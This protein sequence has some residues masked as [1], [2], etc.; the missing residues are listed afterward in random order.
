[1]VKIKH[2]AAYLQY[3]LKILRPDNKTTLTLK[4]LN[5]NLLILDED[6]VE[7]YGHIKKNKPVLRPLSDLFNKI[8]INNVYFVPIIELGEIEFEEYREVKIFD[9]KVWVIA[10]EDAATFEFSFNPKTL[11]FTYTNS[12]RDGNVCFYNQKLIEKLKEWHFDIFGLIK[13]D[14]AVDINSL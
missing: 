3:N 9:G 8:Q 11:N 13:N 14:L 7:K 1:M 12:V 4:G 6:G 2:L 5:G 10:Y